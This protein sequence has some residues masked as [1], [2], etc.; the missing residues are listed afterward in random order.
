MNADFEARP[1]ELAKRGARFCHNPREAVLEWDAIKTGFADTLECLR[2]G[3]FSIIEMSISR[4]RLQRF[5]ES[6][7]HSL[8]KR[9]QIFDAESLKVLSQLERLTLEWIRQAAKTPH[10][11]FVDTPGMSWMGAWQDFCI[12]YASFSQAVEFELTYQELERPPKE[13]QRRKSGS[14]NAGTVIPHEQK[15]RTQ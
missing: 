3:S 5:I 11:H 12:A 15:Q 6:F 4:V 2:A 7:G 13:K 10:H 9:P 1:P 14:G 8:K